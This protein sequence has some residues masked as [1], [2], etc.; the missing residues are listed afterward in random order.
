MSYWLFLIIGATLIGI[1]LMVISIYLSI[2]GLA[3]IQTAIVMILGFAETPTLQIAIWAGLTLINFF[4]L[5]KPLKKILKKDDEPIETFT[6]GGVGVIQNDGNGSFRVSY[7]GTTWAIDNL[8]KLEEVVEHEEVIVK[9]I[10]KNRA[11]IQKK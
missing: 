3:A 8:S 10:I 4:F 9:E 7:N 2:V 11:I 1:D 6:T 5:Q